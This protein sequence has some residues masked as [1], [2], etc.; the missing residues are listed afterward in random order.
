[1]SRDLVVHE[2]SVNDNILYLN[3]YHGG[4]DGR[5]VQLTI[6]NGTYCSM[7]FKEAIDTFQTMIAEIT[8]LNEEYDLNPPWWEQLNKKKSGKHK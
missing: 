3:A 7:T 8:K 5:C 6:Q 4:K 2:T 1:M